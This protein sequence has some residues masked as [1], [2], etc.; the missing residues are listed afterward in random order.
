MTYKQDKQLIIQT[1]NLPASQA[2]S[3]SYTEATGSKAQVSL[4]NNKTS[5]L[6]KYSFYVHSTDS[7]SLFLHAQLET[8]NDDF[9]TD[10]Q[11]V[12]GCQR[13][14][15]G[16]TVDITDKYYKVNTVMF[17]VQDLDREFLRL[18]VRSYSASTECNLHRSDT[19]DGVSDDVCYN[20]SLIVL[21]L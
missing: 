21:E 5:F 2:I 6:Y 12:A 17:I 18:R 20:P 8:S 14:I 19:F 13:N 15:A 9:S 7:G 4:K 3:T 1:S 11:T 10:I 16:D